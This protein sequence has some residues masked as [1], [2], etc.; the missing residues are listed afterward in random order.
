[1]AARLWS[2]RSAKYPMDLKYVYGPED[3]VFDEATLIDEFDT[4][5]DDVVIETADDPPQGKDVHKYNVKKHT[6]VD[7][8]EDET[9]NDL[10]D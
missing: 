5:D 8:N 9:T 4:F 3:V 6:T 2:I 10:D 1:M 7:A